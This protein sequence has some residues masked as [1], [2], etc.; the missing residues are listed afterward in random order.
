MKAGVFSVDEVDTA[1]R[2]SRVGK[3]D[4]I[5]RLTVGLQHGLFSN[6]THL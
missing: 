2:C 4:G 6:P 3:A 1:V 5:D